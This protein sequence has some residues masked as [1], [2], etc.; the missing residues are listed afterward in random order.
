MSR[1]AWFAVAALVAGFIMTGLQ[2]VDFGTGNWDE[3]T[4]VYNLVYA[5]NYEI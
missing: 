3:P 2:G 4:N 1:I 5:D